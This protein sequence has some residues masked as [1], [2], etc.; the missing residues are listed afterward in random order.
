MYA[1][2]PFPLLHEKHVIYYDNNNKTDLFR[3]LD[4]YRERMKTA[5]MIAINGYLHAMKHHRTACLVDYVLRSVEIKL[6]QRMH[7]S[8]ND[9]IHV[10]AYTNTGFDMHSVAIK[11]ERAFKDSKKLNKNS[12]NK[13]L[14]QN[15]FEGGSG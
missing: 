12:P 1:P 9:T 6:A 10:P 15:E 3:K 13:V 2:R 8:S 5:R 7:E 11:F 14:V 4:Y